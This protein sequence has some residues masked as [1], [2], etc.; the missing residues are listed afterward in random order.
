MTA[1]PQPD[2]RSAPAAHDRAGEAAI[3][4]GPDLAHQLAAAQRE[5]REVRAYQVLL[6][7]TIA[8][9]RRAA[10][11]VGRHDLADAITATISTP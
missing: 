6:L 2:A 10:V 8:D 11:A 5:L 1:A 9:I 7:N 3:L 4:D